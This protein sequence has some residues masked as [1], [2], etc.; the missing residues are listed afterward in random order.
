MG[1]DVYLE[2]EKYLWTDWFFA[3]RRRHTRG[4]SDWSS[5]VCSSDLL[6]LDRN[7]Y[8]LRVTEIVGCSNGCRAIEECSA[9]KLVGG[10]GGLKAGDT[11]TAAGSCLTHTGV[12][13]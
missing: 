11:I 6:S 7:D 2:G 4:L 12:S 5:D 9:G 1:R 10:S 8:Q 3:N 13:K